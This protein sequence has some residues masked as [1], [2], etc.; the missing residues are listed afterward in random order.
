M[1]DDEKLEVAEQTDQDAVDSFDED[2]GDETPEVIDKDSDDE[3]MDDDPEKGKPEKEELKEE[4]KKEPEEDPKPSAK[5]IA[6][7]LADK[8]AEEH[9]EEPE[10]EPEPEPVKEEPE[11]KPDKKEVAKELSSYDELPDEI[12]VDGVKIK[13][14]DYKADYPEDYAVAMTLAE[15]I[16]GKQIKALKESLPK[17]TV[18]RKELD[19]IK[20]ILDADLDRTLNSKAYKG[21]IGLFSKEMQAEAKATVK[22]RKGRTDIVQAF[23]KS[24]EFLDEVAVKH[25]DVREI[26]PSKDFKDW[27]AKQPKKIRD[28]S[29]KLDSECADAVLTYYKEDVAQ[30]KVNE[31]DKKLGD[32]K[33]RHDDIHLDTNR[34]KGA[35]PKA[36]G[37]DK[38]DAEAAF[39]EDDD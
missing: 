8:K 37:A 29:T 23:R 39:D 9:V 15:H 34:S 17:D 31:H 25:K 22:T 13:L 14:K 32:K 10:P 19:E 6:E 18:S 7:A 16:A 28:L 24:T 5:E 11:E 3:A 27:L 12:E 35:T 36:K 20:E 2:D 30:R 33:K 26:M 1:P 38:D 21:W 4:P